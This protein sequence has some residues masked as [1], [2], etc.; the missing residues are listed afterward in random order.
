MYTLPKNKEILDSVHGVFVEEMFTSL[1][2][3][4][5]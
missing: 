1:K 5:I 2:E 4:F 3:K